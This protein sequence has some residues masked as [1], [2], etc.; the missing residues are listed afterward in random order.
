MTAFF[1]PKAPT[2]N[3]QPQKFLE[4]LSSLQVRLNYLRP[5]LRK[6]EIA[7]FWEYIIE[8]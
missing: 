2:K 7:D 8:I 6:L 3:C 1:I 4:I 5:I